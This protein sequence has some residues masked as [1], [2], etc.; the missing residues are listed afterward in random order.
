MWRRLKDRWDPETSAASPGPSQFRRWT[1]VGNRMTLGS[2]P[3]A[4]KHP[5]FPAPAPSTLLARTHG[6]FQIPFVGL[7]S[8]RHS[9]TFSMSWRSPWICPCAQRPSPAWG[10]PRAYGGV[11]SL[12]RPGAW[13]RGA[14]CGS[15]VLWPFPQTRASLDCVTRPFPNSWTAIP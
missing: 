9:A 2:Q 12:S 8:F 4:P 1:E 10:V 11:P 7:L 5:S 13:G 6:F 3:A 14:G 15:K